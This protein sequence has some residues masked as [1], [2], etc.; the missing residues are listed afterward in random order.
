MKRRHLEAGRFQDVFWPLLCN[1]SPGMKGARSQTLTPPFPGPSPSLAQRL[2]N[3]SPLPG[4]E[5][6]QWEEGSPL[7]GG[8]LSGASAIRTGEKAGGWGTRVDRSHWSHHPSHM[9]L[10]RVTSW[11][12]FAFFLVN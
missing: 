2:R 1:G 10:G 11:V 3:P 12:S 4:M 7:G 9:A 8:R 6:G 5:C